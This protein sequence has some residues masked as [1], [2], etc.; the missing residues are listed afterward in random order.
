[1][2]LTKTSYSMITAAPYNVADF[3][4]IGNGMTDDTAAIQAALNKVR[5]DRGV[6]QFDGSKIYKI[7]A[8]LEIIWSSQL[9]DKE[10]D[11]KIIGN[12]CLIDASSLSGNQIAFR[13]AGSPTAAIEA[14][15]NVSGIRIDGPEQTT[16]KNDISSAS[17]TT[18]GMSFSYV[19]DVTLE[20]CQVYKFYTGVY[21]TWCWPIYSYRN[22]VS[23]CGRGL[24]LGNSCTLGFHNSQ[25]DE[26]WIGAT[27]QCDG[28]S[29]IHN[30]T[31]SSCLFQNCEYGVVVGVVSARSVYSLIFDNPYFEGVGENAFSFGYDND[32]NATSGTIYNIVIRDGTYSNIGNKIIQGNGYPSGPGELRLLNISNVFGI[33]SL[34]DI[35]GGFRNVYLTPGNSALSAGLYFAG[36]SANALT[37]YRPIDTTAILGS[38]M[39][40]NNT[41][42]PDQYCPSSYFFKRIFM[43]QSTTTT[44]WSLELDDNAT[45]MLEADIVMRRPSASDSSAYKVMC[46]VERNAAG[47]ARLVGSS[48]TVFEQEDVN[49]TVSFVV[50]GNEVRLQSAQSS[51]GQYASGYVKVLRVYRDNWS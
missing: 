10:G 16:I 34:A 51:T 45:Y 8:P 27:I 15:V 21:F 24:Y 2:S 5:D 14:K 39:Y 19:W 9:K 3:G 42:F 49:N 18:T 30:Q 28:A 22:I 50:S 32:L 4:A 23:F 11:I 17:T 44:M 47:S 48:A 33:D 20:D 6:L 40:V 31:F 38:G 37:Q 26:N 35:G 12:G 41:N 13:M 43:T 29:D 1:M 25:Y 7:T 46:C 36:E